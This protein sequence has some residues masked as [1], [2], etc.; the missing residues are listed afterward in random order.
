VTSKEPITRAM[1]RDPNIE[2][3]FRENLKSLIE[4]VRSG[5]VTKLL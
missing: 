2:R 5:D 1:L 4:R 3:S